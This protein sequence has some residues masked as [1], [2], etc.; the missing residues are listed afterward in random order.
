M[1]GDEASKQNNHEKYYSQTL[2]ALQKHV[3]Y[4]VQELDELSEMSWRKDVER[5]PRLPLLLQHNDFVRGT[6]ELVQQN[7]DGMSA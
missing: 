4:L 7:L 6:F 3:D 5:H 2:K 1:A